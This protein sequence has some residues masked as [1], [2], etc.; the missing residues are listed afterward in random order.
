[1]NY[2]YYDE[3]RISRIMLPNNNKNMNN[4]NDENYT[5]NNNYK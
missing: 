4:M 2:S 1:M 5:A 3:L